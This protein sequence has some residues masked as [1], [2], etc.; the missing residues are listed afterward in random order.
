MDSV[1]FEVNNKCNLYCM[2]C[3]QNA[4]NGLP[5]ELSLNKFRECISYTMLQGNREVSLSGGEVFLHSDWFEMVK[6]IQY[7]RQQAIIVTNGTLI[8]NDII[9]ALKKLDRSRLGL[10]ISI[11][12]HNQE[13]NDSIRGFGSFAK[14]L[15]AL[16]LLKSSSLNCIT[17]IQI[18]LTKETVRYVENFLSLANKY[19]P[20]S[21]YFLFPQKWGRALKNWNKIVLTQKEILDA[22]YQVKQIRDEK[23]YRFKIGSAYDSFF[24]SEEIQDITSCSFGEDL[25]IDSAGNVYGCDGCYNSSKLKLGNINEK[26]LFRILLS[27]HFATLINTCKERKTILDMCFTCPLLK[28]CAG[29]CMANAYLSKGSLIEYDEYCDIRLKLYNNKQA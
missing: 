12:G 10:T 17:N 27:K 29:G 18:V 6:S 9:R 22:V 11:D 21:V 23:V 26:P 28:K 14:T 15:A 24:F 16:D 1:C 8:N 25:Y 13:K 5:N 3:F 19:D 20:K 2:H 4:N 7:Y